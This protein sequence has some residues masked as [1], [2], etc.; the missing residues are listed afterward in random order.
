MKPMQLLAVGLVMLAAIHPARAQVSKSTLDSISTPDRVQSQ[1]SPLDFNDGAPSKDTVAKVYDNLDLMH[2][3]EAF[4]NAFQ[5]ASTSAIW[6]GFKQAGVAD[7]TVLVFSELMDAKS[8]F[9]TAN[10]DTIYFW[11]VFDVTWSAGIRGRRRC[12]SVSSTTCGSAG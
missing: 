3:V 1:M 7:N 11:S 6:Q 8:L 5:G 4:V 12:A 2:G 9:L 10:A